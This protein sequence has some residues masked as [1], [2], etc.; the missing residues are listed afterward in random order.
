MNAR[1]LIV[2]D[3][4]VTRQTLT[5]LF[6]QEGYEVFDAA[7]GL[8]MENIMRQERVDVVIMD[9][10][11]PGKNGLELAES[12]RERDNIGLIFLTGRDSEDDRLLALELGAD[13]Y[14]VKPFSPKELEAR[15]RCVLRRVEKEQVAGIPNSGVI[16]VAD[17]RIDTN[18]RQVFRADER[19]RLTG[20]EFSLLE[21][22][23]GRS[24]EPFSR[25]EILKDVWGY[26]PER[27]VDTRVVD[28]HISRLRS[29]LE[30]DPANPELILTARGT[31]YLFQ[32]IIDS[33]APE[34]S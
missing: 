17:L 24:G 23:V 15:I 13:D 11:L 26:T 14:V 5:R 32:R 4:V 34:G 10:N 25:G 29:K 2:E 6:Q 30:D 18:K 28:V 8:Q 9:V 16:Q 7:D 31:G 21:L 27:H 12:L 22:L 1:I 20:M 3:E 19:I 33:V